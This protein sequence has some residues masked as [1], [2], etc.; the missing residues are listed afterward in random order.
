MPA[1]SCVYLAQTEPS[2]HGAGSLMNVSSSRSTTRVGHEPSAPSAAEM[3]VRSERTA[4]RI[5]TSAARRS[6]PAWAP[7]R[8]KSA[9]WYS[10]KTLSTA[11]SACVQQT[12]AAALS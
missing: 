11:H 1:C 12:A 8:S 10:T 7:M 6:D 5:V 9:S 4:S 3:V 2:G